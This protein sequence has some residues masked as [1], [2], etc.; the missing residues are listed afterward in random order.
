MN[1]VTLVSLL[2]FMFNL[3]FDPVALEPPANLVSKV[4]NEMDCSEYAI[5]EKFGNPGETNQEFKMYLKTGKIHPM[6]IQNCRN[7]LDHL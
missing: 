1:M 7:Y 5:F 6:I 3:T 2:D 4:A